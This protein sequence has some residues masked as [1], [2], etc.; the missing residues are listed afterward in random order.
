MLGLFI[1]Y[2]LCDLFLIM[3]NIELACYADDSTLYAVRYSIEEL[4][5]KLQNA[6]KTLFQWFSDSQ[7]ETKFRQMSFYL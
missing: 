2:F 6:S 4:I 3:N 5:V 7:N 1:Q